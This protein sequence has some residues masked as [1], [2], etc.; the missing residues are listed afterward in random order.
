MNIEGVDGVIT[1]KIGKS[2]HA[3][4]AA[5]R[6]GKLFICE[7]SVTATA[8][9]WYLGER[10]IRLGDSDQPDL[11]TVIGNPKSVS[12][13]SGNIYEGIMPLTRATKKR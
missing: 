4:I 5:K 1:T 7:A 10:K 11:F 13:Y 8:V 12:P 9:G 3:S 6:D 2:S